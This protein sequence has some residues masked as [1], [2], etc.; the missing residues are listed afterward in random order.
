M[1]EIDGSLHLVGPSG[2]VRIEARGRSIQVEVPSSPPGPAA[3]PL[4]L[5]RLA[6]LLRRL[7]LSVSVTANGRE[8]AQIPGPARASIRPR[9]FALLR[10]AASRPLSRLPVL[11]RW[12]R[13]L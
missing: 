1:L 12:V 9:F 6:P 2:P 4:D 8:L 10:F 5:D 7:D 13:H 11:L 3:V